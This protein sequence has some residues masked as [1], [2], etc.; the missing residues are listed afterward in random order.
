MEFLLNPVSSTDD[1]ISE[2]SANDITNFDNDYEFRFSDVDDVDAVLI[3]GL[4]SK[5]MKTLT[6]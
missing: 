4:R 5:Q 3:R 1:S 6:P 2:S